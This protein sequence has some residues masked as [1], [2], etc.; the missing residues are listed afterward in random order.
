MR[1]MNTSVFVVMPTWNGA[2]E[3]SGA[4]SAVLAQS[5]KDFTLIVV[6]NGSTDDSRAIIDGFEKKDGRVKSIYL[7]KNYGYTGG[8]NAGLEYALGHKAM[9]VAGCNNDAK[10]H[11]DWLKHLVSFLVNNKTYGVAACK[12]LLGDGKT[13]DSTGEQYT[14][15]GLSYSRGRNERTGNQYDDDI[16]IFGA[17]GGASLYRASMLKQ[18]G[19][20][21]RDFFAYYEDTDLSFRTQLA[22][23]KIGFVPESI[24]Y[25]EQGTTAAR[26]PSGFTTYQT[27]K[28]LPFV[29]WKN[30]PLS[31]LIRVLPRFA[32][33]YW[34]FF[35]SALQR[36]QGGQA[37]RGWFMSILLLP[38]KLIER[39]RIQSRR[40]VSVAY[41]WGMMVHDLPPNA[42]RLRAL[43]RAWGKLS[44]GG[45]A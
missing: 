21:D 23:W 10:P 41:M 39:R 26:M 17:S 28:N 1:Y 19:L 40:K 29:L 38:R 33:A 30:L 11:Q 4:I 22:G 34:L 31:C 24:V 14:S 44:K 16:D 27:M 8:M 18:V 7:S 35:A 6:D 20:F 13:I 45:G 2:K 37:L 43:H 42:S 9:Y 3:L 32:L 25:H 36:G 15:W 5:Y 12:L